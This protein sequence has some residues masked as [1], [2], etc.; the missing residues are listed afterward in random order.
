MYIWAPK[1]FGHVIEPNAWARMP[2]EARLGQPPATA[3]RS[4]NPVRHF[5]CSDD[6][7]KKIEQVVGKP[8]SMEELRAA[9]GT[10]VGKAV[11]LTSKAILDLEKSPRSAKTN[12]LFREIFG[13]FPEFVPKWRASGA[14]WK[15]RG[16]LVALRLKRAA[17][18][19]ATGQI[20]YYCWG[21]PGG[22]RAPTTYEACNYPIGKYIIGFGKG[23]W[24]NL[25]NPAAYY[26]MAMTLLHETLHIYY[27][28]II[29]SNH[30]GTYGNAN[31]Y[32]RFVSEMNGLYLYTHTEKACPSIL[33]RGSRGPEVGK[34][35]SL[36]N[37]WIQLSVG[38]MNLADRPPLLTVNNNFDQATEVAVRAFQKAT[39]GLEANGVT[40][41]ETWRALLL[42]N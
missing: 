3:S 7:R 20:Q 21:C 13:T 31:C 39:G 19:L 14:S 6:D 2:F 34:L 17:G 38:T 27:S 1:S 9:V 32:Q 22:D 36:L 26:Y 30:E 35:Q 15:D 8:V 5:T 28:S 4:N 11:S 40:G 25:K 16:E 18:I 24:E 10:A 29:L 12:T 41:S 37:K 42:W 23:F 33:R